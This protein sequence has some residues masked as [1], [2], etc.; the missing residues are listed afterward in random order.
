MKNQENY[1]DQVRQQGLTV[2]QSEGESNSPPILIID[3]ETSVSGVQHW[4]LQRVRS[5]TANRK[6]QEETLSK[7]PTLL[8]ELE[9]SK[10]QL[11]AELQR[12][13]EIAESLRKDLVHFSTFE[14]ICNS[15]MLR[16]FKIDS[17]SDFA[18]TILKLLQQTMELQIQLLSAQA[19][20]PET[21]KPD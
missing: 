16:N 17:E 2:N 13:C 15:G 14:Q 10:A 11:E 4:T 19:Q 9:E 12:T 8:N 1:L 5:N 18:Q 3:R 6:R 7:V 21:E 20:P